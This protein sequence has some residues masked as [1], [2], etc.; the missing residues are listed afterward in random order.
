MYTPLTLLSQIW[1]ITENPAVS[2][3]LPQIVDTIE[4]V[5]TWAITQEFSAPFSGKKPNSTR[6][7]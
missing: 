4:R 3:Q 2:R 6:I 5:I 7:V 1:K